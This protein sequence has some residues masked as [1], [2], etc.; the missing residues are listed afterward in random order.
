MSLVRTP[1][2]REE[3][4]RNHVFKVGGSKSLVYVIVQNK[5]RMVYPVSC[6]AVCYVTVI[7]LFIK[8]LGWSVQILGV[9][10]SRTPSVCALG[11]EPMVGGCGASPPE[12]ESFSVLG[13]QM[14]EQNYLSLL[15]IFNC[16]LFS[17]PKSG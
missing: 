15:S 14:E 5:I 16:T 11:E 12:A 6:T 8:K 3:Q 10:T 7:T 13:R 2:S 4:G 9:R 17:K 1:M